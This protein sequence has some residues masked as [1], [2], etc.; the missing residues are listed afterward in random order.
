MNSA[1]VFQEDKPLLELAAE[2]F[3]FQILIPPDDH[4][5]VMVHMKPATS[6]SVK[7][8]YDDL[9]MKRRS[10]DGGETVLMPPDLTQAK[11][12][13]HDN[14]FAVSGLPLPDGSTPTP[15][16]QRKWWEMQEDFKELVWR[17]GYD[18]ITSATE[19]SNG[20]GTRNGQPTMLFEVPDHKISCS[21]KLYSVEKQ[22]VEKLTIQ[23]HLGRLTHAER[24]RYRQAVEVVERRRDQYIQGNWGI[25]EKFYDDK[26][27][28]LDG[29]LI[30]G[31]PCVEAN[32]AEWFP[33]VPFSMKV[34][35]MGEVNRELETK[36]G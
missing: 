22:R 6:A 21:W 1:V 2:E 7:T 17:Q 26:V 5:K 4:D 25:V 24:T 9:M 12:F 31:Q 19:L 30:E 33:F 13:V 20:N 35:V 32:R 8:F 36:N 18:A 11:K 29:A 15:E 10:R 3:V 27:K 14:F 23:H 34:F 16:Q 28:R